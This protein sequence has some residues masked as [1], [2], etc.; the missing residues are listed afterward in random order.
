VEGG[1]MSIDLIKKI[2]EEEVKNALDYDKP[3][4]VKTVEDAFDG[5]DNLEEPNEHV[6]EDVPADAEKPQAKVQN[7]KESNSENVV[8]LTEFQLRSLIERCMCGHPSMMDDDH[9]DHHEDEHEDHEGRMAKSQLY[10]TSK[11]AHMIFQL[12][13]DDEQLP[14]WVQSKITKASDYLESVFSYLDYEELDED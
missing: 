12:I 7:I 9:D 5:G 13:E 14:G 3:S 6:P 2:I 10:R 1:P 8:K 11:M 4:E